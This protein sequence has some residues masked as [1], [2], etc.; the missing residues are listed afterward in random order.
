[1]REREDV[2]ACNSVLSDQNMVCMYFKKS[3][4]VTL[5]KKFFLAVC[6]YRDQNFHF[7]GKDKKIFG[8]KRYSSN[9]SLMVIAI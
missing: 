1:M 6:D 9:I 5:D 8:L 4:A 2:G 7:K 3:N